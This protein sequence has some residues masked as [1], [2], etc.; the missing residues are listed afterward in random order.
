MPGP[1]V[2]LG[3][4]GQ[5]L[6]LGEQ[7]VHCLHQL[8]QVVVRPQGSDRFSQRTDLVQLLGRAVPS[9]R[10]AVGIEEFDQVRRRHE[11]L[12]ASHRGVHQGG[13]G[14]QSDLCVMSKHVV[15]S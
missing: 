15:D 13:G 6:G 11:L 12:A 9:T 14:L 10:E 5:S 8:R 2:V 4:E 7:G 1:A 3:Q